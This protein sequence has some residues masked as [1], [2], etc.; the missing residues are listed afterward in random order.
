MS[1]IQWLPA[2]LDLERTRAERHAP[3]AHAAFEGLLG[4]VSTNA[5]APGMQTEAVRPFDCRALL[6][7]VVVRV[8]D[9][10][11][12]V[13]LRWETAEL[14]SLHLEI[15]REGDQVQ[16]T[17]TTDDANAAELLQQHAALLSEL[18]GEEGL[19]LARYTVMAAVSRRLDIDSERND[20]EAEI[21]SLLG[22]IRRASSA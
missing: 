20:S 16:V 12:E 8:T 13:S 1:H 5:T 19:Q 15:S 10:G 7:E 17:L 9:G 4:S 2:D 3:L 22:V 14:G 6:E 21:N 18:L 11:S